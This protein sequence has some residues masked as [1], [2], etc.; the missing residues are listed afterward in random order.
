MKRRKQKYSPADAHE[1][2]RGLADAARQIAR[3]ERAAKTE[4][5]VM[6]KLLELGSPLTQQNYLRLAYWD[7]RTI[8]DLGPEEL[9]ELPEGFEDWPR[10]EKDIQ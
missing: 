8:D 7:D 10:T 6:K 4:D 9:A 3:E 2:I 1:H 5:I